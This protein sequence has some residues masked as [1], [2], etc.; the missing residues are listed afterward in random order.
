MNSVGLR[1]HIG[2]PPP[3]EVRAR[4]AVLRKAS[5]KKVSELFSWLF[6]DSKN[7]AVISESRQ[8][9]DLGEVVASPEALKILRKDRNLEDALMASG[10]V[11][12][13]LLKRL[14]TARIALEKAELDIEPFRSDDGVREA[15]DACGKV[16]KRLESE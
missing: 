2:A 6:G 12:A 9:S 11:R 3:S 16:L 10:G 15:I 1:E 5:R 4:K 7:D 13:R 14:T 8:I